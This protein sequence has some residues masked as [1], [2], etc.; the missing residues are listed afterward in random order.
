[1]FLDSVT[2]KEIFLAVVVLPTDTLF[3]R[4]EG[5]EHFQRCGL[6]TPTMAIKI[7]TNTTS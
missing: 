6:G 4:F 3:R 5:K 2:D 7:F 1:L